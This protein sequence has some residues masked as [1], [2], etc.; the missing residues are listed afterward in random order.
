MTYIEFTKQKLKGLT[1]EELLNK[2]ISEV[3]KKD[4]YKSDLNEII[5]YLYN[6]NK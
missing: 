1:K 3:D 4:Y 6:A 2:F 5:E